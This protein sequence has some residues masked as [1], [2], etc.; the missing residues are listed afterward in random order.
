ML[1]GTNTTLDLLVLEL[2]LHAALLAAVLLGLL[3]L[4][5]PVNAGA[6]DDVLADGGGVE[7]GTGGVALLVSEL[8]PFAA[9]G[10]LGVDV[11]TDHCGLNPAGDLHFL[12]VIV[13][14]V[15]DDGLGAVFVRDHLLRGE[16][17]GVIEFLIVGPVGAAGNWKVLLDR[18]V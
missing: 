5:L 11:F 17:G 2:V 4:C 8:F 3:G 7:G 14:T 6:E 9:F 12:V 13:E 10:D 15:G 18:R 16:R 1:S